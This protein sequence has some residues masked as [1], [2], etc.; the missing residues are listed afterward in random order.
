MISEKTKIA[1]NASVLVVTDIVIRL[2]GT[3]LTITIARKLGA[4]DLGLLAFAISFATP[5]ALL[6][7]FGF[8]NL[9][10]RD[11][12]QD[13]NRTSSYFGT[14]FIIKTI[15]SIIMPVG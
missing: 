2:L 6:A 3:I 13:L 8:N 5:F 7:G 15:F 12:A 10:S 11:V 4:A 1:K 14:I 9:I